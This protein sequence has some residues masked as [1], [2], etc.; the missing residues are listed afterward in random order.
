MTEEVR[1]WECPN[2]HQ[3]FAPGTRKCDQCGKD[4]TRLRHDLVSGAEIHVTR[5]G[6]SERYK[7]TGVAGGPPWVY[8]ANP[9][10]E[11][12]PAPPPARIYIL[13][14][15]DGRISPTGM[16]GVYGS[17]EKAKDSAHYWARS[18]RQCWAE[19]IE[20]PVTWEQADIPLK[21]RGMVDSA[22]GN[23][24]SWICAR[25]GPCRFVVESHEVQDGPLRHTGQE[26]AVSGDA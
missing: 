23:P 15:H 3:V 7:F 22:R 16:L 14:K 10:D 8:Y 5:N 24:I 25:V 6:K 17:Q 12:P 1:T 11:E 20:K 19:L 13:R 26:E 4:G 2:C 9:L 21:W 18:E